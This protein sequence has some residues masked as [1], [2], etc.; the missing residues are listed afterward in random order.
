MITATAA[1][2]FTTRAVL[3]GRE[4]HP[5]RA[6]NGGP[7]SFYDG[8]TRF[9]ELRAREEADA[10]IA[11]T[12][13]S[14][15]FDHGVRTA[16]VIVF[17]HGLTNSPEQFVRLAER[18]SA[19]GDTVLIPR[20][21]RHGFRDRLTRELAQLTAAE[22]KVATLEAI[23][24]ATEFGRSVH[25]LGLSFG[26]LLALWA[27][28]RVELSSAI[29]I[30][31]FV[32]INGVPP[33]VHRVLR[34][35]AGIDRD[36]FHWWDPFAKERNPRTP[37]HAYPGFPQGA[38]AAL[39]EVREELLRDSVARAPAARTLGLLLNWR[40]PV[41]SNAAAIALFDRFRDRGAT[42]VE[43]RLRTDGLHHDIIDPWHQHLPLDD[44]YQAVFEMVPPG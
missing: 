21:P 36:R 22:L 44:I 38:L 32:G 15:L 35:M 40:D 29:G 31:P 42:I 18:F 41:V 39:L 37:P 33:P 24:L 17:F 26:G 13:Y 27:A 20:L 9:A 28:M 5:L 10:R 2:W 11:P 19:A 8:A 3:A 43:H 1:R 4:A 23:A 25:V 14:R 30:A 6:W 34:L 16:R 7:V 12:G